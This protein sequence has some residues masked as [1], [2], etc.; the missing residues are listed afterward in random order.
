MH[1]MLERAADGGATRT[2]NEQKIATTMPQ[3]TDT[4]AIDRR[5]GVSLFGIDRTCRAR[6]ALLTLL[7]SLYFN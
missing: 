1:G 2:A 5:P 7:R 4:A 6:R 3:G